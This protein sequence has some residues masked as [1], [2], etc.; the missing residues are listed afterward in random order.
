VLAGQPEPPTYFA[1]MKRINKAGPRVLR[2]FPTPP[3]LPATAAY[4]LAKQG[5][6]I[7]DLRPAATFAA[8]HIPGTLSIPLNKTLS[9]W[10]G[11]LVAEGQEFTLLL[12]TDT[13]S[14]NPTELQHAVRDLAMVGLDGVTGWLDQ[15]ALAA[16]THAGGTLE[17]VPH[18]SP[19]ALAEA[20]ADGRVHVID[21]RG[22]SEWAEAHIPGSINI[23]VGLLGD[24]L[25]DLP[26]GPIVVHCQS[27]SRSAIAASV[28]RRAGRHD[29]QNLS[30]G[31]G[32]WMAQALPVK[33]GDN[34]DE[35]R[36]NANGNSNSK[37]TA[38]DT[39]VTR[40]G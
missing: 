17:Q 15:H 10:A 24:S 30:G 19:A 12:N 34:H 31:I 2:G 22:A 38:E 18:L 25:E 37:S 39:G 3:K 35:I 4:G 27:G 7:L 13:D 32:A 23:P 6:L 1:T 21:V 9:T 5:A 40:A 36:G 28:L 33:A 11:W 8:A 20:L 16:Y 14:V 29:V 26:S